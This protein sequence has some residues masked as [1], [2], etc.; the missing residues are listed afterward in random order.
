MLMKT[1]G[2]LIRYARLSYGGVSVALGTDAIKYKFR[3]KPSEARLTQITSNVLT[4]DNNFRSF[5]PY[6][7]LLVKISRDRA[8]GPK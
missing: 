4:L 2:S 1:T 6:V 7:C 8:M 3:R 5:L